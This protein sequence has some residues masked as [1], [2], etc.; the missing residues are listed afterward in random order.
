MA[1]SRPMTGL[2]IAMVGGLLLAAPAQSDEAPPGAGPAGLGSPGSAAGQGARPAESSATAALTLPTGQR[3]LVQQSER[4][5]MVWTAPQQ[6][7]GRPLVQL[8]S[9]DG[10]R[11]VPADLLPLLPERLDPRLFDLELLQHRPQDETV[12][13]IVDLVDARGTSAAHDPAA[14]AALADRFAAQ[15]GVTVDR[16][17]T[18]I[19]SVSAEVTGMQFDRLTA[20]VATGEAG[21]SKVWLSGPVRSTL[22]DSTGQI[23]APEAWGQGLTGSGVTVAVLDTGI[24]AEH[25]D[26]AGQVILDMNFSDSPDTI[27]RFG[28]GTHVAGIVAGTGAANADY[29]GVAYGASLLSGKVL[30]DDG[31]G[32]EDDIIAAMEWSADQGADVVNMSLGGWPTDGTDPMSQAL[33]SITEES[34]VLFVVAAGNEGW[35]GNYSVGTPGSADLALTV[36]SVDENDELAFDSSI[37]PR[38]GDD[39]IK[40]DV[41]APGEGIISALSSHAEWWEPI[42]TFYT[43]AS[44]TSMAAP[45]VA[46]AAAILLQD[47]PDL[48]PAQV[49]SLLMGSAVSTAGSVWEEGA[50]RITVPGALTQDVH[51][52]PAS[53]TFGTFAFPQDDLPPVTDD[54]TYD[55]TSDADLTLDLSVEVTD[56]DGQ[57]V[58]GAVEVSPAQVTVPAGASTTVQVTLTPGAAGT[59]LVSG[60]LLASGDQGSVRTPLGFHNEP[61]LF[62]LSITMLDWDS[63]APADSYATVFNTET[64]QLPIFMEWAE[65]GTITARVEAGTYLVVGV[66]EDEDYIDVRVRGHA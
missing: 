35:L 3:V 50:G 27:D 33:N 57:P 59:G 16:Q 23:G 12:S 41:T 38:L 26:L 30:D 40:P 2:V 15:T 60:V 18:S 56:D 62:D 19:G 58:S 36:G 17:L 14:L 4:G 37:G 21:V 49:K 39:A 6:E 55:N 1:R 42:D 64:G 31:Y 22:S 45:H 66:V 48:T 5:Q 51:A 10:L 13:V 28:H 52:L 65:D 43:E 9:E 11:V 61:E 53:L 20:A 34:E 47:N 8:R 29:T 54:V 44:G 7:Q 32:W 63:S 46:G 25:P 24:D